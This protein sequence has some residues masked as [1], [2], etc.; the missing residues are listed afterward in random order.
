MDST[1]ILCRKCSNV[2]AVDAILCT[3][4]CRSFF[5]KQCISNSTTAA[6]GSLKCSECTTGKQSQASANVFKP[7]SDR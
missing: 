2:V 4:P 3:G 5:H 1:V 6:S 7:L